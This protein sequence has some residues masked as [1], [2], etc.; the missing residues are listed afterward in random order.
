MVTEQLAPLNACTYV[1]VLSILLPPAPLTV[2]KISTAV[3]PD[4]VV[5][6]YHT[7]YGVPPQAPGMPESVA[8]NNVPVLFVHVVPGVIDV[9]VAQLSN[10]ANVIF[11]NRTKAIN[12]TVVRVVVGDMVLQGF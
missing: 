2:N 5:N 4:G 7:S 11:E 8:P 6:E 12:A 3:H 1:F 10:W 9:G